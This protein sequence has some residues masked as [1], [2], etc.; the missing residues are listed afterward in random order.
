LTEFLHKSILRTPGA[1]PAAQIDDVT[2][3]YCKRSQM[4]RSSLSLAFILLVGLNLVQ[5][6]AAAQFK[7]VVYHDL[8]ASQPYRVVAAH[9][10]NSG[11]VDLAFADFETQ[12][13]SILLGNGDGTF[14]KQLKFSVPMPIDLAVGDFNEDG[15]QDLAVVELAVTGRG[16]L[17]IYLGD[18][19]GHFHRSAIHTLGLRSSAVAVA[20]FDGDGHLDAAVADEFSGSSVVM[21]FP[22]DGHGELGKNSKCKVPGV[23][24]SIATGDLYG[25]GGYDLAVATIEPAE[26]VVLEND[27]TGRFVTQGYYRGGLGDPQ[28]VKVADL[29]NNGEEDLVV[30]DVFGMYVFLNKGRGS[31]GKP[32]VYPPCSECVVP[33]VCTVADLNLDGHQD[34]ACATGAGTSF[35]FYGNG[36][37]KFKPAHAFKAGFRGNGGLSIAAADLDNDGAPDLIIPIFGFDKV[38]I[39]FNAQ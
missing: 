5:Q 20:D 7:H 31:F 33:R 30:A 23:P 36:Q 2:S 28:N 38:A 8:L 10:T 3:S 32:D 17:A 15:I 34:V 4:Q 1:V 29:R 21:V 18:G 19:T 37:G 39:M 9:F 16:A 26:V 11:N 24:T 14:Q 6:A 13:V 12:H 25:N 22:G 35:F 27:G